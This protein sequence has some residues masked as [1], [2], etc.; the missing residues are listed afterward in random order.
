MSN[1]SIFAAAALL[2]GAGEMID[3]IVDLLLWLRKLSR[4]PRDPWPFG[5]VDEQ[6]LE[7]RVLNFLGLGWLGS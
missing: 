3:Y 6:W 4:R 2:T 1:R 7:E 5:N